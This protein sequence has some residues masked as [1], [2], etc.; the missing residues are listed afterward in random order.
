VK[1]TVALHCLSC[2]VDACSQ[3]RAEELASVIRDMLATSA[4][5]DAESAA[6]WAYHLGR[7]G[8]FIGTVSGSAKP[9]CRGRNVLIFMGWHGCM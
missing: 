9:V 8:F 3:Q 2:P 4:L 5:E 1:K 6:Y 7:T